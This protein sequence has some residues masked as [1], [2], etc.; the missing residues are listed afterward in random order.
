[1]VV[2]ISMIHVCTLIQELRFDFL[3]RL[4]FKLRR[5]YGHSAVVYWYLLV[6]LWVELFVSK[7]LM[8]VGTA[9]CKNASTWSKCN[10]N[11]SKIKIKIK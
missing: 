11:D 9:V 6:R 10:K 4:V 2:R 5:C 3:K 1:M 8:Q 7:G